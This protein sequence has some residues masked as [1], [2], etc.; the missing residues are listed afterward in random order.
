MNVGLFSAASALNSNQIW[1][2]SASENLAGQS[3]PGFKKTQMVVGA[4]V[5]GEIPREYRDVANEGPTSYLF[6]I[7]EAGFN[8]SQGDLKKTEV[9]TDFALEGRGFFVIQTPSG[10]DAFTRDGEF[11]FSADGQLVN[12]EGFPVLGEGG[13]I[14]A[15]PLNN[16]KIIAEADGTIRQGQQIL[17]KLR[18]VDFPDLGNLQPY[19]GGLFKPKEGGGGPVEIPETRVRQGYLESAN[20]ST[21]KEM[22]GLILAL[23]NYEAN[24]KVIQNTDD[25]L[26]KAIQTLGESAS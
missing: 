14:V 18:V 13:P 21:V 6:P 15:N 26:G 12:K 9:K 17:G 1:L 5:E 8:F 4:K 16:A 11:K 7:S 23:R 10:E 2:E 20:V 22:A 24:Q 3:I 25:K 19:S